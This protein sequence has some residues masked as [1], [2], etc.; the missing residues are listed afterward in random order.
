MA[1]CQTT[2]YISV[3]LPDCCSVYQ[4]AVV[5]IKENLNRLKHNV[6]S[7]VDIAIY[8]T[9]KQQLKKSLESVY[10][11]PRVMFYCLSGSLNE[12][13]KHFNIQITWV[14]GYSDVRGYCRADGLWEEL[15]KSPTTARKGNFGEAYYTVQTS[16]ASKKAT[17][18]AN[19][20]WSNTLT[21]RVARQVW[22]KLELER[23]ITWISL[24]RRVLRTVV[25]IQMGHCLFGEQAKRLGLETKMTSVEAVCL[26]LSLQSFLGPKHSQLLRSLLLTSYFTLIFSPIENARL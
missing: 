4:A 19:E 10:V 12:M 5:T 21:C 11:A 23:L 22:P 3:H 25:G 18:S 9:V 24:R 14:P 15:Y 8:V 6:I 1:P 26:F 17:A 16:F 20:R 2:G 7:T 13:S